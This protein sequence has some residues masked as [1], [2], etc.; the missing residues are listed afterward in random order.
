MSL[1]TCQ[2]FSKALD[3]NFTVQVILPLPES[4]DLFRSTP[5]VFPKGNQKFQVLYLL[6]GGYGDCS[7]WQR[8]TRIE[9]YAKDHNLAVVMPSGANSLYTNIPHGPRYYDFY[10]RELPEMMQSI[11]PIS[12]KREHTFIAG[13]SMGGFGAFQA[14]LRNPERFAAAISLSGGLRL[15]G[16]GAMKKP[17][18]D[19]LT[20]P[21]GKELEHFVYEENDILGMAEALKRQNVPLPKLYDA[22]G[23]EDF[24]YPMNCFVRDKLLEMGFDLT[25]EEGPGIHHWDFW[26]TYIQKAICWLPLAEGLVEE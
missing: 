16:E 4:S 12:G 3:G 13:L 14:A 11:F 20:L 26:D 1:F 8:Y 10:T 9:T 15:V 6:H 18:L 23:T 22:C 7:D 21:Y 2:L 25:W 19:L 17:S 5:S 24:T